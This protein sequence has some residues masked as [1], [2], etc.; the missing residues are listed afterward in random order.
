MGRLQVEI[1]HGHDGGGPAQWGAVIALIVLVLFAAAG[2]REIGVMLHEALAIVAIAA[3]SIVGLAV[4]AAVIIITARARAARRASREAAR[5]ADAMAVAALIERLRSH[6][7][8][9]GTDIRPA[10][11]TPRR[12]AGWPLPGQRDEAPRDSNRRRYS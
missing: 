1:R 7:P 12:P 3:F 2:H 6:R 9:P 8:V 5:R 10:L 11:D 4:L